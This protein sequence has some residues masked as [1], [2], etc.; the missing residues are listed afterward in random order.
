MNV[1]KMFPI[2]PSVSSDHPV[3]R[4]HLVTETVI[5]RKDGSRKVVHMARFSNKKAVLTK[6]MTCSNGRED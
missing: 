3:F 2:I 4:L 1:C 5:S 6:S